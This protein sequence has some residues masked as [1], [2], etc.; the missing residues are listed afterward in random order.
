MLF[1]LL[2]IYKNGAVIRL[3]IFYILIKITRIIIFMYSDSI[4]I[5]SE[6]MICSNVIR[7]LDCITVTTCHICIINM[8]IFC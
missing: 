6:V 3:H 8:Y 4:N 1:W 2:C 5:I 7:V